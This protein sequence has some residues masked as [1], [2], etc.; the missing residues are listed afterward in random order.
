MKLSFVSLRPAADRGRKSTHSECGLPECRNKLVWRSPQSRVGISV[1]QHWY[2]GVDCFAEVA[3]KRFAASS[4]RGVFE[5]PPIPRLSIGLAL[6]S[7]GFLTQDQL[8][9]A[10]AQSQLRGERLESVLLEL[11]LANERQI[12]AARAAQWGYP[13]L[14][15]DRVV[16]PVEAD[17]PVTL[18]EMCSAVPLHVSATAQKYLLGF[19]YRVEHSLL[20]SLELMTG[21]RADPCFITPT[22]YAQQF[23]SLMAFS[24]CEEVVFEDAKTPAQM[25]RTVAGFAQEIGAREARFAHCRD[26]AWTR[27]LGKRQTIDV[28]FRIKG[29]VEA[30]N[31]EISRPERRASAS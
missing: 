27:L 31:A 20:N 22:E 4:A 6:L 12:A 7:K 14:G 21:F 16:K 18:L 26:Y 25:G 23:K 2:C 3:R 29:W 8:R 15:Q 9:F 1:G 5:M 10:T 30:E 19:V 11:G 17:I 28:L 13:V 24:D